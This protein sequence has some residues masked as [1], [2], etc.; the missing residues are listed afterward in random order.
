MPLALVRLTSTGGWSIL[1]RMNKPG[2]AR[3]L[4]ISIVAGLAALLLCVGVIAVAQSW[5]LSQANGLSVALYIVLDASQVYARLV[6]VGAALL[7]GALVFAMLGPA[8]QAG[9]GE[10]PPSGAVGRQVAGALIMA[11]V[12]AT[13]VLAG[14]VGGWMAATPTWRDEMAKTRWWLSDATP[15]SIR[16]SAPS[17]VVR[18]NAAVAIATEDDGDH[19]ITRVS[20]DGFEIEPVSL[21]VL[22]TSRLPDGLHT[23]IVE[24]E[25][26]SRRRNR[27]S[28]SAAFRSETQWW[29][30]DKTGPVIT[31]TVP[32][33]VVQGTVLVTL[34]TWDEGEHSVTR[35]TLDGAPLPVAPETRIDTTTL[36]DGEHTLFVEAEDASR[37]RNRSQATAILRSDNLPPTLTLRLDP[38]V[39][40]QGRTQL[41]AVT[42]SEPVGVLTATLG[43]RPLTLAR[44]GDEYW[45][46]IGV[47]AGAAPTATVLSL[48]AADLFGHRADVTATHSITLYKYPEEYLRGDSVDLPPEKVALLQFGA[49]EIAFLDTIF[50]PVTPDVLWRGA[51]MV[52]LQGRQTSPFA[53]RRS[54]NGGPLD[55]YHGGVD[56]AGN[57]GAPVAASARGRV[58]LAEDLKVRGGAVIIDHGLGVYS[59]YYH[60]S[61]ISVKKGQIVERGQTVGLVGSEG[62]STGP[63]L[64]WELR[65]TGN[66]VDPWTWTQRQYP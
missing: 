50:A 7:A 21:F 28:A 55:S 60:L 1:P 10:P 51:F 53:I 14:A 11:L 25:D 35:F 54:Y 27:S 17:E 41:L 38:P 63:H 65:V 36:S 3:R 24:A 34:A 26:A 20:V 52:P 30:N 58:V 16:I 64:H 18:G 2:L 40:A 49:S 31:L 56:I 46:V 59:C 29:M 6:A 66:A 23:I 22:D 61:Q 47:G 9:E 19:S 39:A 13:G 44:S 4:V 33:T 32:M 42:V 5:A 57:T 8:A 15:P 43:G 37:Q 48:G 12:V 45:A 62:L